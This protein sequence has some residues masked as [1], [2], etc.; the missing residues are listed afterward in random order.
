MGA[1]SDPLGGMAIVASVVFLTALFDLVD[2]RPAARSF[3]FLKTFTYTVYFLFRLVLALVASV[4]VASQQPGQTPFIIGFI[5]VVGGVVVLQS[6]AL[7][8]AGN[9][10]VN[11]A[12]LIQTY[13]DVMVKEAIDRR[14][15]AVEAET[16]RLGEQLLRTVTDEQELRR[17]LESLLLQVY[18]GDAGKVVA[19]LDQ[20]QQAAADDPELRRRVFA[21]QIAQGNPDYAWDIINRRPGP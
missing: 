14:A 8:I 20:V 17:D 9:D 3:R 18:S 7:K 19:H 1:Y 5:S 12:N 11:L 15:Q 10:V 4:L 2:I 16:L 21:A 6:F 13:K